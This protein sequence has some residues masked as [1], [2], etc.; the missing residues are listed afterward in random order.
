MIVYIYHY[1]SY[2]KI[3]CPF[4]KEILVR[5]MVFGCLLVIVLFVD[6]LVLF[7]LFLFF[8][9]NFDKECIEMKSIKLLLKSNIIKGPCIQNLLISDTQVFGFY[10][11]LSL[12]FLVA[13]TC[14]YTNF[15]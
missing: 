12:V 13:S 8:F 9:I 14:T 6:I 15:F 11:S 4:T 7:P 3:V 5:F 2:P 1:C 10:F